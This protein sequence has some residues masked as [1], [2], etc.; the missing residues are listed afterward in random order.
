M[1]NY[2]RVIHWFRRDLRLTDN[3]ALSEAL[4]A[5]KEVI[6]VYILSDW[7]RN[8]H[9]TGTG[10]QQFLT[11]CLESLSEDLESIGGRLIFRSGDAVNEL[12]K[13]VKTT[14]AE[15]IYLNRDP[16]PYGIETEKR[17]LETCR[18]IGIELHGS[19]DVVLHEK[20][21]VLTQSAS[22]YRVYTPYSKTWMSL[23]K[24]DPAAKIKKFP[25]SKTLNELKS[26]S[27]DGI[28]HWSL[29]KTDTEIPEAG[30]KAARKRLKNAIESTVLT[31]YAQDRNTPALEATSG[32]GPDLRYGTLSPREIFS[33][34]QKLLDDTRSKSERESIFTFQK[35]LAWRE[36]F[37]AILGH[38][39]EVL[40]TDFNPKWRGLKWGDPDEDNKLERWQNGQTGFP[41]ID[42]GLRQLAATGTMHNRV[43]MIVAMFLT[44]DLHLHWKLGEAHFMRHLI[45][46]EIANNNGGWQWSSGT[47]ADAAP[48]FR[49]QNPWTQT[50]RYDPDGTYIKKWIPELAEVSPKQFRKPAESSAP[51]SPD[52]P[53]PM[54]D[55][56]EERE[57]TLDWF[58][59]HKASSE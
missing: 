2:Q 24:P 29:K 28:A 49:I 1:P 23:S 58:K 17:L 19:K 51:L 50:E 18:S 46:G 59:Q 20:D 7:K 37:M 39:P 30:E 41:I 57:V 55:H 53:L 47:G 21:E 45:D 25:K 5:G 6:P 9:W 33:Q 16:D 22:P 32:I 8:H 35:Q 26:L 3:T 54:V 14:E 11:G 34:S 36:F 48:Y 15:A 38:Y 43:R 42:A 52:Y 56:S 10:R 4:K 40:E 31:R 27:F 12:K 44:K 13:L